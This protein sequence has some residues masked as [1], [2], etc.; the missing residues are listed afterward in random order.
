MPAVRCLDVCKTYRQGEAEVKGLDLIINYSSDATESDTPPEEK[1]I[2]I[3]L[4]ARDGLDVTQD[5][6]EAL[7]R[8]EPEEGKEKAAPPPPPEKKG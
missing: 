4:F 1:R 5:V 3:I 8:P 7:N 2:P 6:L